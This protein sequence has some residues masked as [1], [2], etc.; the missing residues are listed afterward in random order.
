MQVV[1]AV[2]HRIVNDG[3]IA[4]K[5]K[6]VAV[7]SVHHGVVRVHQTVQTQL[8][9]QRLDCVDPVEIGDVVAIASAAVWNCR[10]GVDGNADDRG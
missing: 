6:V 3:V 9:V 2:D 4:L 10:V 5:E 1:L 8:A 7:H